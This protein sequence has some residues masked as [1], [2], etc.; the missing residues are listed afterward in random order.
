[1]RFQSNFNTN[2]KF[3]ATWKKCSEISRAGYKK[4]TYARQHSLRR[5][6]SLKNILNKEVASTCFLPMESYYNTCT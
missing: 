1:M 2:R 6:T 5:K 3:M 4:I